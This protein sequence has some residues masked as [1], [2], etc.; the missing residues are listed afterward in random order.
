MSNWMTPE[1]AKQKWCYERAHII[2]LG[3][4]TV[5]LDPDEAH[6]IVRELKSATSCMGPECMKWRWLDADRKFGNCGLCPRT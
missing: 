6:A 4:A 1:E 5:A 3:A 2:V